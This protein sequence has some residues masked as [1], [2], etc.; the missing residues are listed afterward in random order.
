MR[1]LQ[2]WLV[3]AVVLEGPACLWA[4]QTGAASEEP[5]VVAHFHLSGAV[6]EVPVEDPFGLMAGQVTSLKDLVA[7]LD[8]AG[9]DSQVKAVILTFDGM[10]LG[11]GQL[12]E[13]RH[14]IQRAR[15]AGKRVYVHAEGMRTFTYGLLCAGDHLSVAPQSAMWLM[16]FYGETPYVKDLLDKIGVG[17]DFMHMG[18][19]KSAA[20]IF[21]RTGP[22]EAAE[23]NLNWLYDGWYDALVGMIAQSRGKT[24]EQVRELIDRGP[25]M[26]GQAKEKGLI[27]AVETREQ[28]VARVRKEIEG[29]EKIDNR[30]GEKA[31]PQM[32]FANPLALFSVLAEM[33]KP[34]QVS[35]KDAVGVI[36]VSGA[37]LPGYSQPTF[38][39]TTDAA[40]S[41]DISKALEQAARDPAVKAVV[42][43]VDSPGG[44]AEASEVILNATRQILDAKPFIVSM[45]D[46]A[47]SGGYYISCAADAIFADEATITAS[48]GVVGGKLITTGLWDR[49]GINWVAHKR[50]ANADIFTSSHPFDD[51]QRQVLEDYMRKVYEVFKGH[52]AEGRTGKLRKPLEE[53]AG[54]RVYTGKQARE[55]GLVDEIG[56]LKQAID[57][58]AA[59]AS[60]QDYEVR[61]IPE[62]KDFLAQLLEQSSGGGERPTDISLWGAAGPLA[63]HP[64]LSPL[65]D[66]LSKTEPQRALA[67]RLVLQRIDLIRREGVIMMMPFDVAVY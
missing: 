16:G 29:P 40:F 58:A 52:V 27:D 44:S 15:D 17:T 51:D 47:A 65:L 4:G 36:Y 59:K 14:A 38:F 57:Y 1:R 19:Y 34:A 32:N 12:E 28:F 5:P 45:G 21:T 35:H 13:I 46:V 43:R 62:P 20:E 25:Y 23:E 53:M 26:A 22:S 33:F 56:G 31:G 63:D 18:A 61:I 3:W 66:L 49:L 64:T 55:L 67:L 24:P 60:L 30:Y 6:T 54:G 10:S 50:G 8:Q 41:G 7:R 42:M 48:I 39:G 2:A 37:I 9:A 11:F